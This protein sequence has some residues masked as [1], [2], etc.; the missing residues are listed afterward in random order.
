MTNVIFRIGYEARF[1]FNWFGEK[2]IRLLESIRMKRFESV[3]LYEK[4]LWWYCTLTVLDGYNFDMYHC[5]PLPCEIA[6]SN[7]AIKVT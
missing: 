2:S 7:I 6:I 5:F 1:A 3:T 4:I